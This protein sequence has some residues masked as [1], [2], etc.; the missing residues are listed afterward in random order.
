MIPPPAGYRIITDEDRR[1]PKPESAMY[2]NDNAEWV[3]TMPDATWYPSCTYAVPVTFE[4]VS[5]KSLIQSA[6]PSVAGPEPIRLCLTRDEL[7][8]RALD[9]HNANLPPNDYRSYG[10]LSAFV[11]S[12]FSEGA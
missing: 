10:I 2:F 7:S 9:F 3:I 11:R 1:A 5:L 8:Q 12:L 6:L 4:T